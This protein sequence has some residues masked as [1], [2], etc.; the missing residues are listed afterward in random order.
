MPTNQAATAESPVT[1]GAL[2]A[3]MDDFRRDMQAMTNRLTTRL[4][5]KS[6]SRPSSPAPP[7]SP[8]SEYTPQLR[9]QQTV[10]S[11]P[12]AVKLSTPSSQLDSS[13]AV[14]Q[15]QPSPAKKK[16]NKRTRQ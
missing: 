13:I 3:I 11:T 6:R 14:T 10:T 1:M 5:G 12:L 15:Q 9:T 8:T 16:R 4:D 2:Q 7:A